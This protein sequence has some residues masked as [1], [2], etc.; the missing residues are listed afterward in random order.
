MGPRRTTLLCNPP[1][2]ELVVTFPTHIPRTC[3]RF[4]TNATRQLHPA[5][6]IFRFRS[7]TPRKRYPTGVATC[8]TRYPLNVPVGFLACSVCWNRSLL[9][10]GRASYW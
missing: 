4:W 2:E 5:L 3:K 9:A 8:T 6:A 1:R 10:L 7:T